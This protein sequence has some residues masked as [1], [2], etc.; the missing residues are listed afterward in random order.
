MVPANWRN[1]IPIKYFTLGYLS[2]LLLISTL[3]MGQIKYLANA[4][5]LLLFY[6][7]FDLLWTRWERGKWYVP[8]SSWL[9]ALVLALVAGSELS[10]ILI[11]LLPL[12][13]V[14]C[15]HF[16]KFGRI[17]HIFNPA[18]FALAIVSVFTPVVTWWGVSWGRRVMIFIGIV[19]LYILWSTDRKRI[20]NAF[21][22]SYGVFLAVY[23]VVNGTPID[24]L[25]RLLSNQLVDGTVFF[26]A[27]VMLA[28]PITS[29]FIRPWQQ[30]TYGGMTAL[31]AVLIGY[32]TGVFIWP[33]QDP[34]IYGLLVGNVVAGLWFLPRRVIKG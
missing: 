15:K 1:K 31:A 33:N 13:A 25:P 18:A 6:T 14:F 20:A 32:L 3:A 11:V 9:S 7:I 21:L 30:R 10:L 17:R 28:E 26:F 29:N 8:L 27:T 4:F 12:L 34:L 5:L 23:F 16:L 22:A 2:L 24:E 19:G